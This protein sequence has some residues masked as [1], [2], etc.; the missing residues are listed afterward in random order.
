VVSTELVAVW[1]SR[2]GRLAGEVQRLGREAQTVEIAKGVATGRLTP[3]EGERLSML[4]DLERLG[5]ASSYYSAQMHADRRRLARKFGF[6]P[7]APGAD[8]VRVDLD[9]LLAPYSAAV[10]SAA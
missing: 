8:S 9:A 5:L 4:L 7:N 1:N 3:A 10:A 2:F 6:A